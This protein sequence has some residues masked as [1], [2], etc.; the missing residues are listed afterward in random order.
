MRLLPS[1]S[2]IEPR[3]QTERLSEDDQASQREGEFL[4]TAILN[5]RLKAGRQPPA[6]PGVCTNCLERCHPCAVYCDRDCRDDHEAFL[7]HLA[8]NG[9]CRA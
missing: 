2:G 4:A 9:R 7:A 6:K 3:D 1:V 5:Q 8:R